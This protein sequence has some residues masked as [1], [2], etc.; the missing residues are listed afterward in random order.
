VWRSQGTVVA[1]GSGSRT[2][3]GEVVPPSVKEG[4][5]VLLPEYGGHQISLDNK[6]YTLIRDSEILGV[7]KDK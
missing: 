4:D 1:V 7:L 6:D 2:A 5:R 3:Q